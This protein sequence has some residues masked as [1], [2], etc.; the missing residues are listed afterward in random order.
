MQFDASKFNT[1]MCGEDITTIPRN[2]PEQTIISWNNDD[3]RVIQSNGGI[4]SDV[5]EQLPNGALMVAP[6]SMLSSSLSKSVVHHGVRTTTLY[7]EKNGRVGIRL[8]CINMGMFVQFVAE[9][10]PAS[11]GGIRFGDQILEING[12]ELL[13]LS[14]NE[15]MDLLNSSKDEQTLDLVIRDRPFERTITL[16]KNNVGSLGFAYAD[17][18]ITHIIKS[19]SASRNGLLINQRIL[20]VNGQ[21][22]I[23][24]KVR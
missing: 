16:H 19:T 7:K 13:G 12:I 24:F 8:R 3:R 1:D 5:T 21:N 9:D 11:I 18:K 17:N 22:V 20:E 2:N 14:E 10:S 4:H 15:A 23:G 6:V